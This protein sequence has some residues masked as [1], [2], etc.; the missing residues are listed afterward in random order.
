MIFT[1]TSH[2]HTLRMNTETQD[3]TTQKHTQQVPTNIHNTQG[4]SCIH[5]SWICSQVWHQKVTTLQIAKTF[6]QR[7]TLG[8]PLL[9]LMLFLR[10][11]R[12]KAN[13]LERYLFPK[14]H[15]SLLI[16]SLTQSMDCVNI[17]LHPD[18]TLP[19]ITHEHKHKTLQP[20]QNNLLLQDCEVL[21]MMS[22]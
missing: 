9:Q 16:C 10:Q 21:I 14:V 4:L 3:L 2:C 13:R 1:H 20:V 19:Y 8:L 12:Q 6:S 22:T 5:G 18:C 11:T 7:T 17:E 15:C